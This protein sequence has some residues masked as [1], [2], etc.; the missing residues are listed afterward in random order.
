MEGN[1]DNDLSVR[2]TEKNWVQ[3]TFTDLQEII[4]SVKPQDNFI[5]RHKGVI[6]HVISIGIGSLVYL[7]L[8][9][10]IYDRIK[11]IQNP[12][13]F[14]I[15]IRDFFRT[16][17]WAYYLLEIFLRWSNGLVFAYY[18]RKWLVKLWPEIEFDF[19]PD[20]MNILKVRRQRIWSVSSLVIIP[21][22]I[23]IFLNLL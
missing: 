21:V 16:N 17:L 22:L 2:G 15:G 6:L 14:L 1:H 23:D 13:E 19:G 11:P 5:L 9:F 4:E 20:H 18:I 7:I 3:G 10:L 8:N 12:S